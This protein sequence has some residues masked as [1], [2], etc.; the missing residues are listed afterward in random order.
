MGTSPMVRV[1]AMI[2]LKK[3]SSRPSESCSASQFFS[4]KISPGLV[5]LKLQNNVPH[6]PVF[7]FFDA[8]HY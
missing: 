8:K 5:K 6:S 1:N 7:N 3:F 4:Q 2:V